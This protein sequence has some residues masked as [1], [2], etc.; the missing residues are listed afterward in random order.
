ME[1]KDRINAAMHHAGLEKAELA[2]RS[3]VTKAAVT[4]WLDG[5]TKSLK[6]DKAESLAAATGVSIKWLV[7]GVGLMVNPPSEKLEFGHHHVAEPSS[8]SNINTSTGPCDIKKAL[9]TLAHALTDLDMAGRQQIAPLF[10]SFA[11]APGQVIV[12]DIAE[13]LKKNK[14]S[15]SGAAE[16]SA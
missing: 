15:K 3:R 14:Q 4:Q 9:Q 10:E 1:L 12:D 7:T 13:L 16:R 2:A 5:T 8:P 6:A 11:R